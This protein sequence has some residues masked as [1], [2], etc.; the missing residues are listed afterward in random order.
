[1]KK[2][3][4]KSVVEDDPD[5]AKFVVQSVKVASRIEKSIDKGIKNFKDLFIRIFMKRWRANEKRK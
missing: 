2:G 5:Y 3:L 1:M 4:L